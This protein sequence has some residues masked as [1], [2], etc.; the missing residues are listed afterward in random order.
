MGLVFESLLKEVFVIEFLVGLFSFFLGLLFALSFLEESRKLLSARV[1]KDSSEVRFGHGSCLLAL[2]LEL[3][4]D[5]LLAK[6]RVELTVDPLVLGLL[7]DHRDHSLE[8]FL[9][10]LE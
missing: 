3:E 7:E 8:L 10:D 1:E 6:F 2:S 4:L 5:D 9:V